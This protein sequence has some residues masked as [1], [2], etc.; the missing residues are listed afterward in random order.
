MRPQPADPKNQVLNLLFYL[1]GDQNMRKIIISNLSSLDGFLA[2]PKGEIDWFAWNDEMAQYSKG[3][4]G[5]IDMI[6]FGRVTYELMASYW[7][8]A[9][10]TTDEPVII[11]AMNNLPKIVFSRTLEKAAWKNTTLVKEARKEDILEM[12]RRPGKDIV[13]YGSGSLVSQFTDWGL[14]DDYRI[15]VNPVILADGKPHF[16]GLKDMVKL[17]LLEA[18]AFYSGVVLLH[19][20]PASAK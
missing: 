5:S 7:P 2:G 4:I 3:L 13:I 1:K 16:K 19:Y 18:K 14:I 8:T 6:M 10:P 20:Q 9:G 17:D 12:K 15:F 11:E